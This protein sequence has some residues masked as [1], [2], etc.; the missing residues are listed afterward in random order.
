METQETP[1]SNSIFQSNTAKMIM[2]GLLTLFLLIP[3]EYVKSL[4]SERSSRQNGVIAEINDKWGQDVYIYGPILKIPYT[5]YEETVTVNEKTKETVKQK[6]ASTKYAYFFPEELDINSDTNTKILNRNNYE[7]AVFTTNMKFKGNYVQPNFGIKN[8]A[9]ENIQWDK[10]TILIKTT[11]LKS[12][13]DEV[14]I[15]LGGTNY[16]FEPVYNSTKLDNTEALETRYVDLTKIFF[17]SNSNFNFDITYNGSEQI[18]IVP[19][20]KTTKVSMKSNW[21]S[22][23]FTGNFLPDDKT[24]KITKTGFTANWK[25]LHINRAFSQQAF[26]ILPDLNTYSFGVDFVIPIDQYQQNERASKYGFLVIGLTFLIFFLIQNMSKISIHIFQYSMI[27]LALIMFY[28]LLISITEH[29]NFTKAYVLSGIAVVSLITAYSFSILKNRKFPMFIGF[30]LTGL[31][32]FI[33]VIIQLEN[34]ALLV[35][36]VGLF[37]ILAAVM[38]FSRKI[39]WGK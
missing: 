2:V 36:S 33:Y 25:I 7:A 13:K 1:K 27:G 9:N 24:K 38:Y 14:K 30:S 3:L 22:P 35:G 21:T 23:S 5:S 4:I 39:D 19:I 10:A 32:T 17:G 20:G 28:T 31:Y 6:V 16:T 26:D 29:S 11:N 34:Y 18:K 15:K 12:I 8:I 37:L